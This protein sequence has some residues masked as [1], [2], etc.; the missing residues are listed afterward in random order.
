MSK[1]KTRKKKYKYGYAAKVDE[2]NQYN[3]RL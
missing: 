2:K 3:E 1:Y